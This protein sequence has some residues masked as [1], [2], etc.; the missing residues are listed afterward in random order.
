MYR[1]NSPYENPLARRKTPIEK[2]GE[3]ESNM[4]SLKK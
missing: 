1:T 2:R 3:G 4:N